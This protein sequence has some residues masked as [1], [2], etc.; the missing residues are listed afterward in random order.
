MKIK[1]P[2]YVVFNSATQKYD[3]FVMP[4]PSS[5]SAPVIKN[6][7]TTAWK[8]RSINKVNSKVATKLLELKEQYDS[9]LKE[10]EY[11]KLIFNAKISFEPVI[12]QTYHLYQR[13]NG[14]TF[15]SLLSPDQFNLM[16]LGSFYLNAEM[17]WQKI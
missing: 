16:H 14:E 11:N 4:Y 13:D 6:T 9:I 8:N 12:G 5:V 15:M 1:K 10:F 3:A 7:N 17:I 2:D